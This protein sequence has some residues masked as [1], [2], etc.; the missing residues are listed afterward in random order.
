MRSLFTVS[1]AHKMYLGCT[2]QLQPGIFVRLR[3][4]DF[5]V[6]K[7]YN[8]TDATTAGEVNFKSVLKISVYS[9]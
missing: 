6:S 8:N 5:S 3:A 1:P 4:D 9:I 2:N 7:T